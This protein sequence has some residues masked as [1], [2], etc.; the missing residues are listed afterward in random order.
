[1][2]K[3]GIVYVGTTD[4]LVTY[5][6]P[7]GIGRWRRVG[8]ALAGSPVR[9]IAAADALHLTVLAGEES[10]RSDDGGQSWGPAPRADADALRELLA[11]EG[12]LVTSAQGPAPWK[13][14]HPPAPGSTALA[15]LAGKQEVLLAAIAGGT[16]LLRSEDG[17]QS[18]QQATIAGELAGAV[19][20]ITPASYHM[21]TA[22]AGTDAGQLLRSDDRGR[23]WQ[24]IADVGAAILSL[25]IVR[26][27]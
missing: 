2:A 19:G 14:E 18:W 23:S 4:G 10:R 12:P 13:A 5:S 21:D 24:P 15:A 20:V 16:A 9:A 26:L 25:A 8:R 22:W 3:A 27:I 1:M 6:D 17:G 7:G 11:Q